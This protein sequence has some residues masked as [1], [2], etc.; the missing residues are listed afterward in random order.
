MFICGISSPMYIVNFEDKHVLESFSLE[1]PK[2][3]WLWVGECVS[4]HIL[5]YAQQHIEVWL[6]NCTLQSPRVL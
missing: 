6:W 3:P 1:V 5:A 2:M 4:V